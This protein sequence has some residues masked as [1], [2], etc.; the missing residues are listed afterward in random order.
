M[1]VTL[2]HGFCSTQQWL[3]PCFL[4]R[5]IYSIGEAW[6]GWFLS[7]N[8]LALPTFSSWR[9]WFLSRNELALPTFSSW[10]GW[11]LSR[12]DRLFLSKY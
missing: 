3:L 11:F 6:R 1:E 4:G 12:V 8:E 10:R 2:I 7:R 9:G 5:S